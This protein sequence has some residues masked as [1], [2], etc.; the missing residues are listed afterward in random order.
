MA[1]QKSP[2]KQEVF[3]LEVNPQIRKRGFLQESELYKERE[4]L[5]KYIARKYAR[6]SV[7][8]L[9]YVFIIFRGIVFLEFLIAG[10]K[11]KTDIWLHLLADLSFFLFF[12]VLAI[13]IYISVYLFT[14]KFVQGGITSK[15]PTL[16]LNLAISVVLFLPFY[17]GMKGR[18][19]GV[20]YTEIFFV[21]VLLFEV[22]YVLI[23]SIIISKQKEVRIWE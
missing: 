17:F 22:L 12:V 20:D 23:S 14:L 4:V 3:Y 6:V 13:P 2:P 1:P 7:L 19:G 9:L 18:A 5:Q 15:V 8:Y 16:I 21:A 11:I 10:L